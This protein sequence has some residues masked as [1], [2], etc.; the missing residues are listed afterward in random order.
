MVLC[1]CL[2][3]LLQGQICFPM[4]L[5][6]PYTFIWEKCWVHILDTSYKGYDP[7]ELKLDEEHRG[8]SRHKI[9]KIE[10]IENPDRHLKNQFSTSFPKPLVHLSWNLL[11]SNRT[12][13]GSK[14]AKRVK[15]KSKMDATVANLKICFGH[16]LANHKANKVETYN[17]ATGWH[18]RLT[19]RRKI[20][21]IMP[22]GNS[23]MDAIAAILKNNFWLLLPN[24]GEIWVE[25]H[26]SNR[27]TSRSRIAKTVPVGNP[28]WPQ[29][30][31]Y[32]QLSSSL[33]PRVLF[34]CHG[35]IL[36]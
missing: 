2:T 6:G 10:P 14:W 8:A 33:K 12:S 1:W 36:K 28:R 22:I 26:S 19:C 13:F 23:K 15:W 21:K 32:F 16:L 11:C 27:M 34:G 35:K 17:V 18:N 31:S 30:P 4:H 3:F 7:I 25:T 5:Y 9:A 29:P 20:D 24:H